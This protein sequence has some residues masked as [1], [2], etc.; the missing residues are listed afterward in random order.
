MRSIVGNIEIGDFILMCYLLTGLV[1]N[2]CVSYD[3]V[4]QDLCREVCVRLSVW[5]KYVCDAPSRSFVV[6]QI[7]QFQP[8][9]PGMN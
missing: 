5:N 3:E 8:T 6:L 1:F 2:S 9:L 4:C 7:L